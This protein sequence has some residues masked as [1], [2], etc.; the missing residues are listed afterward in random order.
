VAGGLQIRGLMEGLAQPL[1][2]ACRPEIV[3]LTAKNWA[4]VH[5]ASVQET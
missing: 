4:H 2:Y 1:D 5:L 3:A